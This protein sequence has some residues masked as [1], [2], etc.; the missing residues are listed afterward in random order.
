MWSMLEE[1]MF[2][3][4]RSDTGLRA[5]LPQIEAQVASGKLSPMLA[6]DEIASG[7]GL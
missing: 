3:R 7:L 6:V 2:A 5:R 1:R 4:V